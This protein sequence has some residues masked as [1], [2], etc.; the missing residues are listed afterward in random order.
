MDKSCTQI[1]VQ[2]YYK[3]LNQLMGLFQLSNELDGFCLEPRKLPQALPAGSWISWRQ[4]MSKRTIKPGTHLEES[5]LEHTSV[6]VMC[7]YFMILHQTTCQ[8]YLEMALCKRKGEGVQQIIK[9][10]A[11]PK[12]G[13]W[14]SRPESISVTHNSLFVGMPLLRVRQ[15]PCSANVKSSFLHSIQAKK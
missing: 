12:A 11:S 15:S 7:Y 10:S 2:S 1:I 8:N 5:S 14:L 3:E 13:T 6:V 4:N 9:H